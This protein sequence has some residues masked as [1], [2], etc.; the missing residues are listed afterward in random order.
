MDA[1]R[2]PCPKCQTQNPFDSNFCL[3]CGFKLKEPA[4]SAS[5]FKQI[6]VYLISFFLPPFGLIP[7]FKYLRSNDQKLKNIGWIAIFIT[8]I[9][10]IIS[11]YTGMLLYNEINSQVQQQLQNL[12]F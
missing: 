6:S 8:M 3:N 1:L 10:I 12:S 11:I 2:I 5:L 7:A 9:S 4:P